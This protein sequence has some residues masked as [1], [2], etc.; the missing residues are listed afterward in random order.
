MNSGDGGI[1]N[2][3]NIKSD[4]KTR[5]DETA[6]SFAIV[7]CEDSP[8]Y[9]VWGARSDLNCKKK[10]PKMLKMKFGDWIDKRGKKKNA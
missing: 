2:I 8:N 4:K 3:T 5:K 6:G 10:T 7:G 1:W 9:Q